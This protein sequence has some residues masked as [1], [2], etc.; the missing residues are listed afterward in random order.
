MFVGFSSRFRS[1]FQNSRLGYIQTSGNRPRA[2]QL[3]CRRS[4]L[5]FLEELEG[6]GHN[7]EQLNYFVLV[8]A[9]GE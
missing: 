6:E 5:V 7:I 9:G 4:L 3:Y 2:G 1:N 8:S